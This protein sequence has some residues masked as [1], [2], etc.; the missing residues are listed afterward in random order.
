MK[1]EKIERRPSS[2]ERLEVLRDLFPEVFTDGRVNVERLR[3][4]DVP[5]DTFVQFFDSELADEWVAIWPDS[6]LSG[7]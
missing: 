5:R 1:P 6:R 3:E 7:A 2:E 4:L